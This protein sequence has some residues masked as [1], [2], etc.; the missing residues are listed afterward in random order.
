MTKPKKPQKPKPA[1]QQAAE[2]EQQEQLGEALADYDTYVKARAA[3]IWA[4]DDTGHDLS[5]EEQLFVRS[6]IIDRNPVAAMRRLGHHAEDSKVLK[7]RADRYL[8]KPEVA[9]CVETLAKRLMEKLEITA[10]RVQRQMAA[11]AF[12]DPREVMTFDGYGVNLLHSRFWSPEQAAAIQ[13]IKMGQ[14]GVEIKLYDRLRASE[15]L[16][17]QLGVQP[18]DDAASRAEAAR[19]GAEQVIHDILSYYD[20]TEPKALPAPAE[21]GEPEATGTKH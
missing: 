20:R 6:Y 17:K 4:Y 11:I 14:N 5:L 12:F 10:E 19:V 16:A 2:A 21:E 8:S 13:S 9:S 7:R 18:D 15:L 1:E 3:E